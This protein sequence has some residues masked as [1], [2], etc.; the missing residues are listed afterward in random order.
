MKRRRINCANCDREFEQNYDRHM[1][2][3]GTC[4]REKR[5]ELG[6]PTTYDLDVF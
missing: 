5:E 1:Y 2:C 4:A 3:S 6:L